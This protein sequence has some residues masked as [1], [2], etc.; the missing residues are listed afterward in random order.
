MQN[1]WMLERR[2][3]F[4][5][6]A[7]ALRRS[8]AVVLLGPR[9]VGKTTLARG[10]LPAD[11]AQYLDLEDPAVEARMEVPMALVSGMRVN[12]RV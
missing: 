4:A 9:Q 5:E 6:V 10:V 8:P 1:T 2:A 12:G 7:A 11:A 3:L